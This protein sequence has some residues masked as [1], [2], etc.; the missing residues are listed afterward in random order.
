MS[1]PEKFVR[2]ARKN[3]LENYFKQRR[4][5]ELYGDLQRKQNE[6]K[7]T[8]EAV[9]KSSHRPPAWTHNLTLS[10][11]FLPLSDTPCLRT[12]LQSEAGHWQCSIAISCQQ[13]YYMWTK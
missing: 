10:P 5:S 13:D 2:I 4:E 9:S 8:R 7:T 6:E 11:L 12:P 3:F 1:C